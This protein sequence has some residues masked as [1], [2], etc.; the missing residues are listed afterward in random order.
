[1]VSDVKDIQKALLFPLYLN[2]IFLKAKIKNHN[3]ETWTSDLYRTSCGCLREILLDYSFNKSD[4][5]AFK[6]RGKDNRTNMNL[7]FYERGSFV[8][9]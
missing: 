8:F 5:K 9:C 7:S 2:F 1:M 3:Q 4:N 6:N